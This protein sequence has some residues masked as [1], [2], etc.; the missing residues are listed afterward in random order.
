MKLRVL[1]F[2]FVYRSMEEEINS[3]ALIIDDEPDICFLLNGILKKLNFST[4]TV[5]SIAAANTILLSFQPKII[6]LDNHLPDG[7]GVDFIETIKIKNPKAK[8]IM[9]TAHHSASDRNLAYNQGASDFIG[10]PFT[11]D[12]IHNSIK[13]VLETA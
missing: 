8:I 5:N 13:H 9:I 12:A 6:F 11:K 1:V 3:N 4:E 7:L 2:Q 10:K